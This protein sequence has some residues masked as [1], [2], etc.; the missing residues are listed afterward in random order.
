MSMTM[1]NISIDDAEL[2]ELRWYAQHRCALPSHALQGEI[3]AE[4]LRAMIRAVFESESIEVP[5]DLP[6]AEPSGRIVIDAVPLAQS[7]PG[8]TKA[9][10]AR[11]KGLVDKT[12]DGDPK[13]VIHI[14]KQAGPG[15]ERHVPVAVNGR[16]MLIPRAQNVEIPYRFYEALR[17]AVETRYEEVPAKGDQPSYLRPIEVLS[18]PFHAVRMPD[19]A[20]IEAWRKPQDDEGL[21]EQQRE[22]ERRRRREELKK[23]GLVA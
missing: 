3:S 7:L 2:A 8:T 13:V 23:E 12:S 14:P 22:V 11:A 16:L 5:N 17:N 15:G 4:R 1:K 9:K 18:Y 10:A 21:A 20:E 6:P 19:A